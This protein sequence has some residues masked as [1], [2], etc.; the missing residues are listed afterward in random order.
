VARIYPLE[1]RS[2]SFARTVGQSMNKRLI[3]RLMHE[4]V[5]GLCSSGVYFFRGDFACILRGVAL[6]YVPRGVYIWDF[7]FPLFDFFGPNL[8]YSDRAPERAFIAKDE[9]SESAIVDYVLTSP[10]GRNAF[11]TDASPT[12]TEF[13]QYLVGC[14]SLLNPN[15]QLIHAAALILLCQESRANAMLDEVQP[16][17]HPDDARHCERLRASLRQGPDAARSLLEQVRKENLMAFGLT[18]SV[19]P[20]PSTNPGS[21]G[22]ACL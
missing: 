15:A 16:R 3:T 1:P 20:T 17:L 9:M 2:Q 4:R 13:V 6:E 19:S 21:Q 8:N 18:L 11:C 5:N 10:E 14:N 12:L 7:W 22:G